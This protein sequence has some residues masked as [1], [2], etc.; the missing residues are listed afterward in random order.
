MND[1]ISML[2]VTMNEKFGEINGKFSEINGKFSEI[3]VWA[4]TVLGGGL[5]FGILA[6]V[7]RAF[8][9]I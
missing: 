1:R 2:H 9:W 8:H 5:G 7:A 6:V 3:K 4:L